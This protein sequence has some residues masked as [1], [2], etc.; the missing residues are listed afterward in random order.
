MHSLRVMQRTQCFERDF[1][2]EFKKRRDLKPQVAIKS[3][4]TFWCSIAQ[5]FCSHPRLHFPFFYFIY[6][7]LAWHELVLCKSLCTGWANSLGA[8]QVAIIST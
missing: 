4:Q 1:S 8:L 2:E 6:L 5:A 3:G 7:S